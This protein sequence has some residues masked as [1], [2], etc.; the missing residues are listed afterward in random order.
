MRILITGATGNAG[1]ALLRRLRAEPDTEI[2]GV[3]RRV[4]ALG[5]GEP[6]DGVRWH[7]ADVGDPAVVAPLTGWLAGV[8][9]VVHLAWQIQP[10]HDRERLRRTNVDGTRHVLEAVRR[11]GV[12]VLVHASSV[13]VYGEGPKDR[14]VTESHPA[15]GIPT[16]TY[17]QDKVAA[18]AL[19]RAATG[20][21]IVMLRP[22]LIFQHDA[23]AG[24]ARLF[25]GPLPPVS[26][27][28]FRR[29]P[30]I[31]DHPRL[32]VQAVHADDVADA[33]LRAIRADVSGAFN[34]VADPVLEPAGLAHHLRGRTVPVPLGVLRGL[35]G[36]TWRARLQP[37]DPGW[38]DLAVGVPLLDAGRAA[39]ELG[40]S[41]R[42]DAWAALDELLRGMSH[43]AG[44]ASAALRS[45]S[46]LDLLPGHGNPQ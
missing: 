26:L 6:Y 33:Y 20:P 14:A 18:E 39:A 44:T 22:G 31:P 10:S 35:A 27:L 32:R 5:A 23:G 9:A 42:Y 34:L 12:P 30:V 40:W 28:R 4:P 21:R 13:G 37:T 45:T 38:V 24:I 19:L 25:L 17:S 3:A 43:H 41:P 36:A 46:L 15:T 7:A 29:V 16:S 8:D 2:I 1:T 11:A